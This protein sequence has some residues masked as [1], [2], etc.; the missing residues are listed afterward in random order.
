LT[1]QLQALG[2]PRLQETNALTSERPNIPLSEL[3]GARITG[4]LSVVDQWI[5]DVRT[6][7]AE[8]EIKD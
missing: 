8:P 3:T 2:I 7:A 4:L 1:S 5:E 6:H